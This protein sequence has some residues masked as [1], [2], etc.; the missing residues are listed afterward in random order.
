MA[1]K[2]SVSVA[3]SKLTSVAKEMGALVE[4][5]SGYLIVTKPG[6]GS[7]QVLVEAFLKKGATES[8]TRWVELRGKGKTPYVSESP[9]VIFHDHSSPSIKRR[10]DT[11]K[12]EEEILWSFRLLIADL[13]GVV[14]EESTE[15]ESI[16]QAA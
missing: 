10:L 2:G 6:E 11:D 13:M 5:T 9:N 16:E 7:K 1:Y 14:V 3:T 4:T 12:S 8:I 15:E